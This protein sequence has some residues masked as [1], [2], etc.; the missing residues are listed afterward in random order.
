MSDEP[1]FHIQGSAGRAVSITTIIVLGALLFGA[2][3][4]CDRVGQQTQKSFQTCIQA[5]HAPEACK[6]ALP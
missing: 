2:G 5:G 1:L 6:K 4:F 3:V